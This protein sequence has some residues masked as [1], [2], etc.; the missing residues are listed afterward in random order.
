MNVQLKIQRFNPDKDKKPYFK[1]YNVEVEPTDRVLDALL[2]VKGE[3]DGSLTLR[4]SCAHGICGSDGMK[5]NG[6]NVLACKVLV[7]NEKQP[8]TIEPMQGI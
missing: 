8:I 1:E 7:R 3:L 4:K 5:V 2:A 6:R